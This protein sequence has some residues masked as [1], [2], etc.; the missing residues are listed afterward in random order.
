MTTEGTGR[1]YFDDMY[2]SS[3]DPWGFDTRWYERRKYQLTLA[4]LPLQH[5][6]RGVEPGCANGALTEMLA[7][8]CDELV[9]Y[10]LVDEAAHRARERLAQHPHVEVRCAR[11]P[12]WWPDGAS[13][14]V[15]WS[16]V[17]YY[18]DLAQSDAALNGLA[19]CL[20]PGGHLVAVHYTGATDYPRGGDEIGPWLDETAFLRRLVDHRDESFDLGVWERRPELPVHA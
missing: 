12:D 13:D 17:M 7:P 3:D 9:A 14:L 6:R 15:V 5:Y 20:E 11:F 2:R 10:E 4:A 18:L 19:R 1:E 16:E 8:R